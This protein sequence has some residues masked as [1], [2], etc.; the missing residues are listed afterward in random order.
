MSARVAGAA[1]QAEALLAAGRRSEAEAAAKRSR[2]AL[3][4]GRAK[5]KGSQRNYFDRF[6]EPF[7]RLAEAEVDLLGSDPAAG[8]RAILALADALAVDPRFDAW[9]EGLFRLERVS[10]AARR[11]GRADLAGQVEQRMRKIDPDYTPGSRSAPIRAARGAPA[12]AAST[13]SAR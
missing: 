6:A 5:L 3:E 7:T 10:A 12:S 11:L 2:G 1:V 8:E 4:E 9:G 13:A